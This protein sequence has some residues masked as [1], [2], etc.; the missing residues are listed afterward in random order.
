MRR[1]T[2]RFGCLGILLMGALYVA[3]RVWS[4]GPLEKGSAVFEFGVLM[5]AVIYLNDGLE[6]IK[7]RR[8]RRKNLPPNG[9]AWRA[10]VAVSKRARGI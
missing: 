3:W 10:F 2:T 6:W 4:E 8:S 5:L 9:E 1:S 7:E